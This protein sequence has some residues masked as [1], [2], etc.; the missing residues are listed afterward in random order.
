MTEEKQSRTH[1][2]GFASLT[3][4][5]RRE[6]ASKGGKS[7]PAEKRSYSM[8][9]ELAAAAGKKGGLVCPPEKRTYSVDKELASRA[10]K[11]G[12]SAKRDPNP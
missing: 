12:G 10:G 4:E 11:I 6:I 5:R 8:N 3:P 2:R 9:R 1:L 7:V